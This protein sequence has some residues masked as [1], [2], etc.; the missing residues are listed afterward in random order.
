[1]SSTDDTEPMTDTV[2][3]MAA[4]AAIQMPKLRVMELWNAKGPYIFRY[5]VTARGASIT[6]KSRS[7]KDVAMLDD[8]HTASYHHP[9]LRYKEISQRFEALEV[10]GV[11]EDATHGTAIFKHLRLADDIL[12]P[13]SHFLLRCRKFARSRFKQVNKRNDEAGETDE[14]D[15]K[16][17]DGETDGDSEE[18]EGDQDTVDVDSDW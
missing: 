16:D 18:N 3:T 12:D 9:H 8:W 4:Q 2:I 11:N 15:N 7:R 14:D 10:Q 1:M 6:I 13:R 17:E 5:E